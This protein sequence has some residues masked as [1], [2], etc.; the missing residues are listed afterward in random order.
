[1]DAHLGYVA[2][3][4]DDPRR[5]ADF[6]AEHFDM[7][8]LGESP[9]GD[10][11]ITDGWVNVS[12]LKARPGVEGAS[13]RPG[14]SHFGVAVKDLEEFKRN[15]RKFMPNAELLP[16][17]GDLHHGEYRV[18]DP[19]GLP[20][21]I[22]TKNFGVSGEPRQLPR[23]RHFA[24][25]CPKNDDVCDFFTNVFEFREVSTSKRRRFDQSVNRFVGD[26]NINVAILGGAVRPLDTN[27]NRGEQYPNEKAREI[28]TKRGFQH[29]GFVVES[30]Q[31]VM[32]AQPSDL[33][34]WT[35]RRGGVDMAEW[36]VFDPELNGIDLSE[37]KGFEVD[38]DRWVNA[39]GS[40]ISTAERFG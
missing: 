30:T 14:L 28:N 32:D 29:F 27:P 16:E 13:G 7:M 40:G 9:E 21:S 10:I 39:K 31:A 25:F 17:R 18:L 6:Y 36:R 15:L 3:V 34:Q 1:M 26:G 38:Y 5:L 22:S 8:T 4:C 24:L 23:I 19:N 35:N 12:L 33:A 20:V 11:S 37:K 2:I